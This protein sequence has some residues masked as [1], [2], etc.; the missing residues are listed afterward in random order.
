MTELLLF[1][2]AQ[3]LTARCLPDY[4]EHAAALLKRRVLSF[5][6]KSSS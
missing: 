2:H 5:L 3:G 6:D 1:H 4:D